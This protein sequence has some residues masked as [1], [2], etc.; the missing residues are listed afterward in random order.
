M[1]KW[2]ETCLD[3]ERTPCCPTCRAEMPRAYYSRIAARRLTPEDAPVVWEDEIDAD[4][5]GWLATHAR[6]C[7]ECRVWIEKNGGCAHMT[8]MRC[9]REFCWDCLV[10]GCPVHHFTPEFYARVIAAI[11]KNICAMVMI[12]GTAFPRAQAPLEQTFLFFANSLLVLESIVS[13]CAI[14]QPLS[15]LIRIRWF[16]RLH[17][18]GAPVPGLVLLSVYL[19]ALFFCYQYYFTWTSH[20][21]VRDVTLTLASACLMCFAERIGDVLCAF[22]HNNYDGCHFAFLSS[23]AI[24]AIAT[25]I[26]RLGNTCESCHV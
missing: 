11:I 16:G 8:C 23:I 10:P 9:R 1:A 25:I 5:R 14:V 26:I 20:V 3:A 13:V 12:G 4:L 7:P 6:R 17:D 24:A 18:E 2:I 21:S 15:N 19:T 22:I